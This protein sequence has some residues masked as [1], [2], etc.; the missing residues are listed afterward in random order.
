MEMAVNEGQRQR[1]LAGRDYLSDSQG[2]LFVF[3]Q[4]QEYGMWMKNM[5]IPLD[6]IFLDKSLSVVSIAENL[7]PCQERYCPTVSAGQEILYVLEIKA[8][9]AEKEKIKVGQKAEFSRN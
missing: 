9:L 6:M 8:G 4:E 7:Q 2:M 1:G 3:N 5:K